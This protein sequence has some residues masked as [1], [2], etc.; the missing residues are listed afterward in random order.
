[1][2]TLPTKNKMVDMINRVVTDDIGHLKNISEE[3]KINAQ[4]ILRMLVLQKSNELSQNRLSKQL[5]TSSANVK[6]ILNLLEKTQLLFHCESYGTSS[7]KS[8]K[9]GNII[10]LQV[11]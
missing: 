11:V 1:M 8:N 2:D 7:N 5:Q 4:R 3:N 10:L 9:F 6:L